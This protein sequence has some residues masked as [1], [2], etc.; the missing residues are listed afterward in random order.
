[1]ARV[2]RHDHPLAVL[3]LDLDDFK[4]VNDRFGHH[5]GDSVLKM[6]ADRIR[7]GSRA[8]DV[9]ARVGGDEFVVLLPNAAGIDTARTAADR[10]A[11]AL[12]EPYTIGG[13]Q[14]RCAASIGLLM[15][16]RRYSDPS[17]VLRDA[18]RAMYAAKQAG[19]SRVEVFEKS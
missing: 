6:A 9:P 5:A 8:G 14:I 17:V 15:V 3:Y 13:N 11:D 16:D 18:D 4:H 10:V 12:A 19:K 7:R 1:L 2:D